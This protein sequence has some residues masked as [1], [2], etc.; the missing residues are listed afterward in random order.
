MVGRSKSRSFAGI[1][2]RVC[3]RLDG[4]KESFLSQTGKEI[5]TKAVVQAIPTYTMSVFRLLKTLSAH[6]NSLISRFWW[7]SHKK[8]KGVILTSWEKLG[9]SKQGGGMGFRELEAFN[10]TLLAKQGWRILQNP[11][12]LVAR[13]YKEKYFPKDTFLDAK[14]GSRPSFAWKSISQAH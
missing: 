14:V 9:K 2:A 5:L 1:Q 11:E 13:V 12:S 8:E 6:L 3:K 4:W 7:N 10:L